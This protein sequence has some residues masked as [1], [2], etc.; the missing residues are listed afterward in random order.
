MTAAPVYTTTTSRWID[1]TDSCGA[2]FTV[3]AP[4]HGFR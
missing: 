4:R 3:V 2:M 1:L